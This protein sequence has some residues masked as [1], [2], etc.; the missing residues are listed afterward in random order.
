[1]EDVQLESS[2]AEVEEGQQE[3]L[4]QLADLRGDKNAA[5]RETRCKDA[6][7]QD[8][9]EV[10]EDQ[11]DQVLILA[12]CVQI[13]RKEG[14]DIGYYSCRN[15]HAAYRCLLRDHEADLGGKLA[16]IHDFK[17]ACDIDFEFSRDLEVDESN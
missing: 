13:S 5:K 14:E 12:H 7:Q 9:L 15:K 1:V 3:V 16:D 17:L 10:H 2:Q 11:E 6:T 4:N 8:S